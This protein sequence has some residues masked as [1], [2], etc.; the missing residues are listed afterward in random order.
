MMVLNK[1][2]G[3]KKIKDESIG[4]KVKK[5]KQQMGRFKRGNMV[6]IKKGSLPSKKQS[7]KVKRE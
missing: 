1:R 2:K 3:I 6:L 7:K 5:L 4:K